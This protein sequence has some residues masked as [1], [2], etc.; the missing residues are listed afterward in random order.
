MAACCDDL[1]HRHRDRHLLVLT[2][3]VANPAAIAAYL[4]AGFVDT[5]ELFHGGSAGAQ[6]IMLHTLR[7]VPTTP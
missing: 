5:G 7:P 3:N 1:R 2:V 6:H 4:R